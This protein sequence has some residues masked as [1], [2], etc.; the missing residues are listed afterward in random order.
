MVYLSIWNLYEWGLQNPAT[1]EALLATFQALSGSWVLFRLISRPPSPFYGLQNGRIKYGYQMDVQMYRWMDGLGSIGL[2]S[3]YS[4]SYYIIIHRLQD[5]ISIGAT[6]RK[7]LYSIH[8]ALL[9]TKKA[10]RKKNEKRWTSFFLYLS[11]SR[12]TSSYSI[13]TSLNLATCPPRIWK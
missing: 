7:H 6:A 2:Q 10:K 9:F 8:Q 12:T 4:L 1:S 11:L 5:I 13:R 3:I